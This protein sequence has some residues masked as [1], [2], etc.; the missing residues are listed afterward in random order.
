M[1]EFKSAAKKM[2]F[3]K[4]PSWL[5]S[6][7]PSSSDAQVYTPSTKRYAMFL[8]PPPTP[9]IKTKVHD[10]KDG[11][12]RHSSGP[13]MQ[14]RVVPKPIICMKSSRETTSNNYVDR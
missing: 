4:C 12:V 10:Q 13:M 8:F 2:I 7:I 5:T 11:L 9:D 14:G 1:P 3:A 6:Y